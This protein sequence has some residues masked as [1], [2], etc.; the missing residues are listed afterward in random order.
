MAKLLSFIPSVTLLSLFW[1]YMQVQIFL[2]LKLRLVGVRF[3]DKH[4]KR[5][6]ITSVDTL[7]YHNVSCQPGLVK[8]TR[9]QGP[10]EYVTPA[11]KFNHGG[12]LT[13][14]WHLFL[15]ILM[16][17]LGAQESLRQTSNALRRVVLYCTTL[18]DIQLTVLYSSLTIQPFPPLHSYDVPGVAK[19]IL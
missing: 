12:I 7:F 5:R 14:C 6:W 18:A 15:L 19:Q 3:K 9:Y 2:M 17:L 1:Y 13:F 16:V 11:Y 8:T 4:L 10:C